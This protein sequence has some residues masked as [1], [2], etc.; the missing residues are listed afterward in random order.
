[1]KNYA[2]AVLNNFDAENKIYFIE[3]ENN[4]KALKLAI[5]ASLKTDEDRANMKDWFSTLS[6]TDY[7]A[8][9]VELLNS[10]Y[11][12]DTKELPND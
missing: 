6:D 4:C 3:A 8:L 10:E 11:A 7:D 1:M 5:I 12:V 9:K 2:V